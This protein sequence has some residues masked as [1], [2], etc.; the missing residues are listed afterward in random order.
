MEVFPASW[1][2]CLSWRISS[3]SCWWSRRLWSLECCIIGQSGPWGGGGFLV[4]LR[5]F[6]N[7]DQ[8]LFKVQEGSHYVRQPS[9]TS[10]RRYF[11][12]DKEANPRWRSAALAP[13]CYDI[14]EMRDGEDTWPTG[15][16]GIKEGRRRR[17]SCTRCRLLCWWTGPNAG[18]HAWSWR[19]EAEGVI[20]N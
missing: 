17:R 6:C 3:M 12:V 7:P 14:T 15:A 16:C 19:M 9:P 18:H 2:Q 10:C 11:Q 8:A 13:S 4:R 1:V 20:S 5:P